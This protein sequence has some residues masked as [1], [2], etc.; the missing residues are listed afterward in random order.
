MS[1]VP[2]TDEVLQ[3]I[4]SGEYD[5][6][7]MNYANGDMVG[8][9]GDF[10]AAR[11]AMETLDNCLGRVVPAVL[12]AGGKLVITGDHGNAEQMTDP[13]NGG[14]HTAHTADNPVPAILVDPQRTGARLRPGV[15]ADVAPTLLALMGLEQP[16]E[17]TGSPLFA[18][19]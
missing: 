8:H 10:A 16:P 4:R 7:I 14:P 13:D 17:M 19:E 6:I 18:K 12:E 3:R 5:L 9:T 11:Q 15:L 2:V 1:A